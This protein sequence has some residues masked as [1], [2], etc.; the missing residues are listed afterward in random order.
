[1]LLFYVRE[2][3]MKKIL[4]LCALALS[5]G[6]ISAS[7]DPLMKYDYFDA[8]YQWRYNDQEDVDNGN[9][10][11]TKL[12]YSPVDNLAL[13]GGYNY[14]RADVFGSG[15]NFNE[16]TYGAVGYYEICPGMHVLGRVGGKHFNANG[17]VAGEHFS[18]GID[19]AYAGIGSR[20]LLT[21]EI[22]VDAD[23]TYVNLSGATW[24]YAGTGFYTIAEN[25]ALK[26]AVSIDND[27]DVALTGG[28]RLAM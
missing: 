3:S 21:D 8:A 27:T 14:S 15:F 23:I 11:D 28:I 17:S 25:V 7:A 6:A 12:S 18:E 9:G 13:E 5:F 10:L 1:V 22:E 16:W 24:T 20:Y 2:K 26:A 19:R 4:S